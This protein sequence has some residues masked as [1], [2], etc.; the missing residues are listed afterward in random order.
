M[1][2]TETLLQHWKGVM[3]NKSGMHIIITFY[4]VNTRQRF[5]DLF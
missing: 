2:S 1:K 3:V 4:E 5:K